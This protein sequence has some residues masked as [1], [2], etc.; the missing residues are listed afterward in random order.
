MQNDLLS[1]TTKKCENKKGQYINP[2]YLSCLHNESGN[3][4]FFSNI[5]YK[6][7]L[8]GMDILLFSL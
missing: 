1:F 6:E 7:F 4:Q 3:K 5:S 8:K 2:Y